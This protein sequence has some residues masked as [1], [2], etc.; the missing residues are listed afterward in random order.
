MMLF[1]RDVNRSGAGFVDSGRTPPLW[2]GGVLGCRPLAILLRRGRGDDD[3]TTA[4]L[5][6]L[7]PSVVD[8][9]DDDGF[10]I[11]LGLNALLVRRRPSPCC[12]SCSLCEYVGVAALLPL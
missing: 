1:R 10:F 11:L 5:V 6:L 2:R 3:V 9:G 7:A 12:S 8:S 4:L